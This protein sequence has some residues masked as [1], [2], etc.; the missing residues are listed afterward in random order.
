MARGAPSPPRPPIESETLPEHLDA[1]GADAATRRFAEALQ[2]EGLAAIDLGPESLALCDQAARDV[3]PLFMDPEVRRVQDAW[4]R[5]AAVRS[6]ATLPGVLRTL[7]TVYDRRPFPFQTLNFRRGSEQE[8]HRDAMH[9]HSAPA[10][11]MCGLWIAL[12]DVRPDAGPL[13]YYP[14]SHRSPYPDA[15]PANRGLSGAA[16]VERLARQLAEAAAPARQALLKRG[17]AVVWTANLAHG[18]APVSSPDATRRSLV[19]H[20]YFEDCSYFTPLVTGFDPDRR[21]LRAPANVLTGTWVWPR[22]DGRRLPIRP[23]AV[24]NS[25]GQA[26][27]RKVHRLS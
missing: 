22:E 18:G 3:E 21:K 4:R 8:P 16:F 5:S 23:T 25:A 14:G 2:I 12:E 10:G 1:V 15:D 13:T 20:Y 7:E 9:F 17:Q 24:L 6:L 26:L 19:V 27:L 11:F